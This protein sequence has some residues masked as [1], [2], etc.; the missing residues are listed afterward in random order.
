MKKLTKAQINDIFINMPL[1]EKYS[2]LWDALDYMEQYNG[3][4]KMDCIILAMGYKS[5]NSGGYFKETI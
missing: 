2:V 3:R 1:K 4:S 5:D